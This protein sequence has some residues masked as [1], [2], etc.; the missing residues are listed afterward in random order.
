MDRILQ[1]TPTTLSN[2]WYEDGA[3]VDPGTVTIGITRADGT[4]LVAAGTATTGT[5]A[6]ARSYTLDTDDTALLDTLTATWTS[7]TKGTLTTVVEVAGGFLFTI[8]EARTVKP[9]DSTATYT[10][11]Q[12]AAART[13]AEQA[14]EDACGQ[15]FV[16]RYSIETFHGTGADTLLLKP[17]LRA[18]RTASV[19]GTALVGT[20]LTG[21]VAMPSGELWRQ[22]YWTYGRGNVT[23]GYEHGHDTP[24]L[25]VSRAAI[26]LAKH[27]LVDGPFDDRATSISTDDGTFSLVTPGL[28]GSAFGIPEVDAVVQRYDVSVG[29]A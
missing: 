13:M 6:A 27:F 21:L 26:L 16:P 7:P 23:I 17:R 22:A 11:A 15:A 28:R 8:S 1:H 25:R 29:I 4:T 19:D 20:D 10:A 3:V 2:T 9:L 14:L 24:P 12:I 18:V 5:G